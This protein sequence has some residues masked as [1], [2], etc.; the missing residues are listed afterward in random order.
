M[1]VIEPLR[2]LLGLHRP[3]LLHVAADL[4]QGP[5]VVMLHGIASNAETFAEVWPELHGRRRI[6]LDLLGFGESPLGER[7]TI[8]EHVAAIHRTIRSLRL[9]GPFTLVGHSLGALLSARYA[10]VHPRAVERLV[11]VAPPVY[12]MPAE[13]GDPG[14]RKRIDVYLRAYEFLRSHPEFAVRA[15]A[16]VARLLRLGTTLQITERNW[17]AFSRTLRNCIESQTT[18]ADIAAV[19]APIDVVYGTLD[20]FFAPGAFQIIERMK[21]VR[22]RRVLGHD[23]IVRG[24]LAAET[25][26]AILAAPS[27]TPH[28]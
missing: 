14:E 17:D 23:H 22:V 1:S 2:R 6:A 15:S 20:Q 28:R 25:V 5:A 4:G 13:I 27:R 3:P 24:R 18:V 8:E 9:P 19:R 12:L 26:E 11:L 21:H 10:A 7:Y 16:H